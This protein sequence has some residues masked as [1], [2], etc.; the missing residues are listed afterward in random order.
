MIAACTLGSGCDITHRDGALQPSLISTIPIFQGQR[1]TF[2]QSL[3]H[4]LHD[5]S[6]AAAAACAVRSLKPYRAL[7]LILSLA[8]SSSTVRQL[9]NVQSRPGSWSINARNGSVLVLTPR[10]RPRG[11]EH[12]ADLD[13]S[14]AQRRLLSPRA[15]MSARHLLLIC[16]KRTP[17]A[18]GDGE[19]GA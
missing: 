18:V 7:R 8:S 4:H 19:T 17:S 14:Q 5:L 9:G 2:D 13:F 6:Y 15:C 10:E 3:E 11:K 1:Q 12:E 16:W